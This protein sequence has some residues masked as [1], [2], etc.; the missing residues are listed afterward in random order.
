MPDTLTQ[1]FRW[2]NPEHGKKGWGTKLDLNRAENDAILW[3]DRRDNYI[4]Q[5][6]ECSDGGGLNLDVSK[7]ICY[8]EGRIYYPVASTEALAAS[9]RN[10]VCLLK[11]VITISLTLPV[12]PEYNL[13]AIVD[14]DATTITNILDVRKKG[15]IPSVFNEAINGICDIWQRGSV[16]VVNGSTGIYTMDR[17]IVDAPGTA[18]INVN[19]QSHDIQQTLIP[20]RPRNFA[21]FNLTN[22]GGADDYVRAQM[23]I[24]NPERFFNKTIC[25]AFYADI[26]TTKKITISAQFVTNQTYRGLNYYETITLTPGFKKYLVFFDLGN[27]P[28]PANFDDFLQI[29]FWFSNRTNNPHFPE[30]LPQTGVF[31][32]SEIEIYESDKELFTIKR[33]YEETLD[34]CYFYYQNSYWWGASKTWQNNYE[35]ILNNDN[36][37][38]TALFPNTKLFRTMRNTP[39]ITFISPGTGLTGRVRYSEGANDVVVSSSSRTSLQYLCNYILLAA[40]VPVDHRIEYH[41]EANSEL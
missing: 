36:A 39:S 35:R 29:A 23:R 13:L 15:T 19:K 33:S 20:S 21:R 37:P 3:Q 22:S 41:W 30:P 2:I 28:G 27:E 9:E 16:V 14:T 7:G 34:D 11:D 38:T 8:E 25:I 1:Q 12:L 6:V 18:Y 10:Y 17:V 5:G 26:G 32:I 40:S 4:H 31:D 24:I